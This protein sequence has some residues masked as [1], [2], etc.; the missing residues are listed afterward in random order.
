[1]IC[2]NSKCNKEIVDTYVCPECCKAI[3]CSEDCLKIDNKLHGLTCQTEFFALGDLL[4]T[5][6]ILGKGSYGKVVLVQHVRSKLKYA[7]KIIKKDKVCYRTPI[8]VFLREIA[9]HKTLCHPN[10]VKLHGHIEDSTKIYLLLEYVD[11]G[12]I[13]SLLKKKIKLTE[14]EA[15]EI[16][17]QA[18]ASVNYLHDS[19]LMHR[20]IKSE[21]FLITKSGTIKLC[22]FGWCAFNTNPHSTF[23]GTAD[24]MAP[25]MIASE[26]YNKK[27]DIWSLGILLYE[28]IH[29]S[30]PF[31]SA[32]IFDKLKEID[33]DTIPFRSS[34]S[35]ELSDLI[36]QILNKSPESRP[37]IKE[38]LKHSWFTMTAA[39]KFNPGSTISHTKYGEGKILSVQGLMCLAEF[40]DQVV[41]FLDFELEK[42]CELIEND[43]ILQNHHQASKLRAKSKK[44]TLKLPILKPPTKVIR[45]KSSKKPR[46]IL[47]MSFNTLL[48]NFNPFN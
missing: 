16:F 45:C 20:D 36:R 22:D 35:P 46:P 23:C 12:T 14:V 8:E 33:S 27:V 15:C 17:K 5:K 42:N 21:N 9:I 10:I 44:H 37:E 25:E 39:S 38:F 34:I 19:Q 28:L 47:D 11:G 2:K 6:K 31:L 29:G 13:F 32:N 30:P 4:P 43:K 41:E 24:Y 3:Y 18:C 40:P 7:L 48:P 1:M 26:S